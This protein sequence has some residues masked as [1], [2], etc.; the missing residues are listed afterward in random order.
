VEET[1]IMRLLCDTIC[2]L[3]T[4][5]L[6]PPSGSGQ[7]TCAKIGN[8]QLYTKGETIHKTIQK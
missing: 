2:Y 1:P 6:F 7:E 8:G 5:V 4:A 3:V